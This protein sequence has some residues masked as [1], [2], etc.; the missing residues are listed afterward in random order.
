MSSPRSRVSSVDARDNSSRI[1]LFDHGRRMAIKSLVTGSIA[2]TATFAGATTT[3][4]RAEYAP[5]TGST[6]PYRA[7]S[8]S[9][10]WNFPSMP[11]TS[12]ERRVSSTTT[13]PTEV[14]R[15]IAIVEGM[16]ATEEG[17]KERLQ[18]FH[19][20][21]RGWN[22]YDAPPISANT[23]AAAT[24][25]LI[26]M[27]ALNTPPDRVL[28]S[29]AGG[30]ALSYGRGSRKADIEFFPDG[31]VLLLLRAPSENLPPEITDVDPTAIE[32]AVRSIRDWLR[33]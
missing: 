26:E 30:V 2:L 27:Y 24:S 8:Y 21:S 5:A 32:S 20:L 18:R 23:I 4:A 12:A 13:D 33:A 22:S 1:S 10:A 15:R 11:F 19:N 14:L 16:R 17:L 28:P 9:A 6:S 25:A 31:E 7:R 3:C 29:P